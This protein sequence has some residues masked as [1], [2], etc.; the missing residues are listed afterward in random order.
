MRLEGLGQLKNPVTSSGFDPTTFLLVASCLNQLRYSVPQHRREIIQGD[1]RFKQPFC[2]DRK[3]TEL[4]PEY[5]FIPNVFYFTDTKIFYDYPQTI[6]LCA[7]TAFLRKAVQYIFP[8][9]V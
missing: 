1:F 4:Q 7:F 3:S 2:E 9:G 6:L 5:I 8:A